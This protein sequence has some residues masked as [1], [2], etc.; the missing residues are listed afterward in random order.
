M[1]SAL[2]LSCCL[3]VFYHIVTQWNTS[4]MR[5]LVFFKIIPSEQSL[6]LAIL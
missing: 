6:S 2:L 5:V 1:S 3:I 4:V